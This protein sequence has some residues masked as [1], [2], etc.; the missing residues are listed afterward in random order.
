MTLWI[1]LAFVGVPIIE[2]ALFIKVGGLIGLWPTIAIVIAT[3]VAGTAMIRHQGLNTLQRVQQ[4]LDAQRL[5]VRELFDGI[6]LLF[7]GALLLTP[8]FFTDSV[9]FALLLPPLRGI[10]GRWVLRA[11]QNAKGVRFHYQGP[12]PPGSRAGP[13]IEGDAVEIKGDIEQPPTDERP[14]GGN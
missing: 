12:P 8:G 13:I 14:G 2:I 3:A 10:L 11:L 1:L 5:P 4:E 9:G 6:C 7:A